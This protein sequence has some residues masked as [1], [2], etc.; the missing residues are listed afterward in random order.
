MVG[1][2]SLAGEVE[3]ECRRDEGGA[4]AAAAATKAGLGDAEPST[5]NGLAARN[6]GAFGCRRSVLAAVRRPR[7]AVVDILWSPSR[8]CFFN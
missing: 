7:L 3:K 2:D 4:A 5:L 1:A 8:M 6:P